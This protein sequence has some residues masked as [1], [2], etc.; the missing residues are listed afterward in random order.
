M[1]TYIAVFLTGACGTQVAAIQQADVVFGR[2]QVEKFIHDRPDTG[3]IINQHPKL[4][5]QLTLLFAD[6]GQG[7][8]GQVEHVH[9]DHQE[10]KDHFALHLPAGRTRPSLVQVTNQAKVSPIDKCVY[11]V[12]ELY[13]A[14]ADR[15]TSALIP[16]ILENQISR[17]DYARTLV[18]SE[19][20]AGNKTREFFLKYPIGDVNVKV[21]QEYYY[22]IMRYSGDFSEYLR[23]WVHSRDPDNPFEY[24]R[25][26][27]DEI[28]SEAHKSRK[29]RV[30]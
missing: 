15:R 7:N 19:F 27:Y 18:H 20:E 17:E 6:S 16:M 23:T 21:N 5:E 24:Y 1:L 22:Y 2:E 26:Q 3:A 4:K 14:R 13:N 10:P 8:N 28:L 25:K 29:G 9:W 30:R 12:H 11:L